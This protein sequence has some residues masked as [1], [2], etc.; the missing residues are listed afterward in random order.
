MVNKTVVLI[1]LIFGVIQPV[2]SET[3]QTQ[4]F[5]DQYSIWD[6]TS[7]P[8]CW[9]CGGY[10]TE[11]QWVKDQISKTWEANSKLRF[12]GWG[13]CKGIVAAFS[14]IHID[15]KDESSAPHTDGLGKGLVGRGMVLNY[16]GYKTCMGIS[17]S[18]GIGNYEKDAQ[19]YADWGVEYLKYDNCY[20]TPN[21]VNSYV[22][23]AL[24]QAQYTEMSNALVATGKPL[25]FSICSWA[26]S[27]DWMRDAGNLWRSTGD[28]HDSWGEYGTYWAESVM[29]IIDKNE[30][31]HKYAG[32]GHWN[33]PDMLEVGN[34]GMSAT[35]YKSHFS[36]W[37]I[38][39]SPLI[40]GNDVRNMDST[41]KAILTNKEAIAV[42]QDSAG[43]QGQRIRKNGDLEVWVKQLGSYTGNKKAVLLFNR[44]SASASISVTWD[45]IGL[46][47]NKAATVRDLW[48]HKDIGSVTGTYSATIGSHDVAMLLIEGTSKYNAPSATSF[49]S[50][51]AFFEVGSGWGPVEKDMSNGE[52]SG[53]DGKTITINGKAFSKGLG[54]HAFSKVAVKTAKVC[55]RFTS[56]I[57][58][59]DEASNGA[60]SVVFEVWGDAKKLF[61]SPAIKKGDIAQPVDL[62]ISGIEELSLVVTTAGDSGKY[63]HADWADAK[64]S[65]DPVALYSKPVVSIKELRDYD[66]QTS[67]EVVY[68]TLPKQSAVNIR[69][70][71]AD[72][73]LLGT[74]QNDI[75][76]AGRHML[77]IKNQLS[78]KVSL[79]Q[80]MI[81][82][83]MRAGSVEK[84]VRMMIK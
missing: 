2:W 10:E 67:G 18:G 80:G 6:K 76:G 62:D 14:G 57:G 44:G 35:E 63:D 33:D 74:L 64:V 49:V 45:E 77:D 83:V 26:F 1:F 39:A 54:V 42:N 51:L 13:R 71:R 4:G 81:V 78:G 52:K 25:V 53:G 40:A 79:A 24:L 56:T 17:E 22:D 7:I 32:P 66:L 59:D 65:V 68:Y 15:I 43:I 29:E 48:S 34:G 60:G 23:Q 82:C 55:S 27:G 9:E 47:T 41:T 58:L 20:L 31:L 75:V 69:L 19:T 12:T 3:E 37:C 61:T 73:R 46:L 84:T 38:M 30:P 50:D 8:V 70:Y 5:V 72:G 11:K 28:I 16:R 36:L 21:D